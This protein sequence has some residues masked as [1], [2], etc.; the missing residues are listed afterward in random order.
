ML[1]CQS[2]LIYHIGFYRVPVLNYL[3]DREHKFV[4]VQAIPFLL[5]LLGMVHLVGRGHWL[6]HRL[7]ARSYLQQAASVITFTVPGIPIA[8]GR[9][10][11]A[12]RKGIPRTYTPKDTA[13]HER[14]VAS[15]GRLACRTPLEGA[16][17]LEVR[18]Y[19]PIPKTLTVAAKQAVANG[20]R[21]PATRPDADNV[22]KLV[23]D[24]LNGIC[25]KDD[26]QLVEVICRKYYG[27]VPCTVVTICEI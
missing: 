8:K 10:R 4:L 14:T 21:R 12:M 15:C 18:S 7:L 23:A 9:P 25:Y 1:T 6:R 17:R 5:F 20:T 22:L 19:H 26:N 11:F 24:A 13:A 3:E 27:V 2:V 16:L